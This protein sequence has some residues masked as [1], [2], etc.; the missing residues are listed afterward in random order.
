M[1]AIIFQVRLSSLL[2]PI[3]ARSSG[4]RVLAS[5]ARSGGSIPPGRTIRK[6]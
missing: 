1:S 5:E 3:C 4:D 2:K 6:S